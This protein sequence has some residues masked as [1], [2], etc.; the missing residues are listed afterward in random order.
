MKRFIPLL[1]LLLWLLCGCSAP[2]GPAEPMPAAPTAATVSVPSTAPTAIP[3]TK[4]AETTAP[5]PSQPEPDDTDFVRVLDYLPNA[6]QHLVYAT[7]DNF[8]GQPIYDFSDAWL[9]YGTV[10]K[11]MAVSRDL[12]ALGYGLL[13]WDGFR[14]VSA[15]FRLWEI[16]PDPTYVANPETGFSSHSRGNT[17]D[18]TLTDVE[19]KLLEMPT[20]FD[21][22]SPLADRDYSDCTEAARE[23]A[24]LLQRTMEDHGFSGYFGEWWHFSDTERYPVEEGFTPV[25]PTLLYARCNEFITLRT[26][27]DTAADAIT[28]I[29]KDDTFLL[30]AQSGDFFLV[31]YR[32]L[33]GYVLSSY[34]APVDNP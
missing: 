24:F 2:S 21:V 26:A 23:H 7:E 29:P 28:R 11:L 12:E 32:G 22:F 30:L 5:V 6:R 8:T 17:L 4:P 16:C 14:P 10:K 3:E 1:F 18:L 20:G 34:T 31:D 33:R 19:G 27:P 25:P 15:Q 13:I 9:R